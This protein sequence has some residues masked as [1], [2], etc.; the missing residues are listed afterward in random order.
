MIGR[1]S[2]SILEPLGV[3]LVSWKHPRRPWEQLEGHVGTKGLNFST[4]V[5][6][7]ASHFE[8]FSGTDGQ[9][10]GVVFGFV[11]M[12]SGSTPMSDLKSGTWGS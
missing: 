7:S 8:S 11:S 6:V 9:N 10:F 5:T 4:F 3:I 2:A 1:L 12:F